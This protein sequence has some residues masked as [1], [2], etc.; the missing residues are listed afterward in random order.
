MHV[1]LYNRCWTWVSLRTMQV[2][3]RVQG[4]TLSLK[5]RHN[6]FKVQ[7]M[8]SPSNK[9]PCQPV[10]L[11]ICK[12]F[13]WSAFVLTVDPQQGRIKRWS[14]SSGTS[15][16]L[17][18]A[19]RTRSVVRNLCFLHQCCRFR[20]RWMQRLALLCHWINVDGRF[21]YLDRICIVPSLR[22]R[23]VQSPRQERKQRTSQMICHWS[24]FGSFCMKLL[25]EA[26]G[27]EIG[28]SLSVLAGVILSEGGEESLLS[29]MAIICGSWRGGGRKSR[30]EVVGLDQDESPSSLNSRKRTDEVWICVSR[31]TLIGHQWRTTTKAPLVPS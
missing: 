30:F 17:R 21:L 5:C 7:R 31:L 13:G 10:L 6:H 2:M 11:I 12:Y 3:L 18:W 1:K 28:L 26:A 20:R 14:R 23:R 25:R 8:W 15:G 9:S 4:T 29:V 19:D 27:T 16:V 22:M 24:F